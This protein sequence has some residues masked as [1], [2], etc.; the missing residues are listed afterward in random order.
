MA[1]AIRHTFF[2][3][4]CCQVDLKIV[5]QIDLL[6]LFFGSRNLLLS[7]IFALA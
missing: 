7:D 6:V 3:L 4:L 2:I 1:A 5:F